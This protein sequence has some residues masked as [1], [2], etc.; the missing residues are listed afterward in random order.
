[1]NQ[2]KRRF[3]FF[4]FLSLGITL[5]IG[6]Y[7]GKY[8]GQIKARYF[9]LN[10][11]CLDTDKII[12]LCS[13]LPVEIAED[14]LNEFPEIYNLISSPPISTL[15]RNKSS[16]YTDRLGK[17]TGS[18]RENYDKYLCF[19]FDKRTYILEPTLIYELGWLYLI[20]LSEYPEGIRR[21][22]LTDLDQFPPLRSYIRSLDETIDKMSSS[23]LDPEASGTTR[24]YD[25]GNSQQNIEETLK[26]MNDF[27][28]KRTREIDSVL[29]SQDHV[30]WM[31]LFAEK[32][33]E[34]KPG[35]W[36][37]L[38]KKL[39]W[40]EKGIR[41]IC[42][43]YLIIVYSEVSTEDILINIKHHRIPR[44]LFASL[45]LLLGILSAKRVYARNE[46][47]AIN[48]GWSIYIADFIIIVALC[49]GSYCVIDYFLVHAFKMTSIISDA[50]FRAVCSVGYLP[51]MLIFSWFSANMCG[52]SILID[53]KG[54]RIYY[55]ASTAFLSWGSI[56]GVTL[57]ETYVAV[58]RLGTLVPRKF[59][60]NLVFI[61]ADKKYSLF[62][63]GLRSIKNRV[64]DRIRL[65]APDRLSNDIDIIEQQW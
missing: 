64:T 22:E 56:E 38:N 9:Y 63:P 45:F 20:G 55:P 39:G 1:M 48:P 5:A 33:I 32:R 30:K 44:Y 26:A 58:G 61:S 15:E 41:F 46:G 36:A 25:P 31:Q 57:K 60:T 24:P 3:L 27:S 65:F 21:L 18:F 10:A 23:K 62:E 53:S 13:R 49:V 4:L 52:Q 59:Q 29:N 6:P 11:V 7:S 35:T 37:S 16:I 47:I 34:I 42:N 40:S 2:Y 17:F 43:D 12:R 8:K 50:A 54:I 14:G 51:V 19:T 28:E